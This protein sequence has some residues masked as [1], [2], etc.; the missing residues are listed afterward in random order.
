LR[1]SVAA[2]ASFVRRDKAARFGIQSIT[3]VAIAGGVLEYG[4]ANAS[5]DVSR[6]LPKG[7]PYIGNF[8]RQKLSKYSL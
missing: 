2:C 6:R 1:I 3:L 7:N 5:W 8:H 4:S